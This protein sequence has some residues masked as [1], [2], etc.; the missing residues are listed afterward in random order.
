[1]V[2]PFE[3]VS[4]GYRIRCQ[5]SFKSWD[6][7]GKESWFEINGYA[8]SVPSGDHEGAFWVIQ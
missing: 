4:I 7:K 8:Q 1:M 2:V 3:P 6:N 5:I